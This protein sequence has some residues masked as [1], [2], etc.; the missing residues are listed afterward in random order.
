MENFT[1]L[2]LL[3]LSFFVHLCSAQNNATTHTLFNA[4][5]PVTTV[6]IND[7]KGLRSVAYYVSSGLA[8]IDGDVVYGTTA[9][10]NNVIVHTGIAQRDELLQE[11]R[12]QRRANSIFANSGQLWPGGVIKYKYDTPATETKLQQRIKEAI[13]RWTS[14]VPCISFVQQP[15]STTPSSDVVTVIDGDG[16]Y[17][18]VAGDVPGVSKWMSPCGVNEATHEW[19]HVLGLHHEQK[20]HDREFYTHFKCENVVDYPFNVPLSDV[21][22]K[23][24]GKT[25]HCCGQACQFVI[26]LSTYSNFFGLENGGKYDLD[27]LM[28]YR[29]NCFAK[30]GTEVLTVGP[31]NNPS[32]PSVGDIARIKELYGC[33]GSVPNPIPGGIC[34]ISCKPLQNTCHQPS[35][36]TCIYPNPAHATPHSY[37]ACRPGFKSAAL[38][39][40]ITKHWRL[41]VIGQEHRVWV[42]EGVECNTLC[43]GFGVDSCK[44]VAMLPDSCV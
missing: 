30:P 42:A 10:F 25:D 3:L 37:C 41:P 39:T 26:D 24:C 36:Q 33:G 15:S 19:G 18:T 5:I 13:A 44:E 23:C 40:D 43:D 28:H 32:N 2:P 8:I 20:R 16:C 7:T 9:E 17:A 27:S 34:P 12:K 29:R 14:V 4:S 1:L 21:K 22:E 31:T 11:A 38:N 6:L 35:A